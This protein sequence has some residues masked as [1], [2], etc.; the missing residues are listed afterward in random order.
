VH[1]INIY[2]FI[3]LYILDCKPRYVFCCRLYRY[4]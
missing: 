3:G 4:H 1:I 2:I